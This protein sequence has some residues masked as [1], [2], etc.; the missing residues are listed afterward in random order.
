MSESA[1]ETGAPVA[2]I[3]PGYYD[4]AWND[5][6]L[7]SYTESSAQHASNKLNKRVGY[8]AGQPPPPSA[9][10]PGNGMPPPPSDAQARP[11]SAKPLV[12]VNLPPPPSM[13]APPPPTCTPSIG[14]PPNSSGDAAENSR[15]G[16]QEIGTQ[17]CD[18]ASQFCGD[19][20]VDIIK[21]LKLLEKSLA[22]GSLNPRMETILLEFCSALTNGELNEAERKLTTLGADYAGECAQWIIGLRHILTSKQKLAPAQEEVKPAGT[23]PFFMPVPP[24]PNQ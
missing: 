6:P 23:M 12:D 22:S 10:L 17:L 3:A 24:T 8:P 19:K 21:R 2:P 7:F 5:P 18:Q 14:P 9:T 16:R 4:R 15:L 20:A 13:G 1:K 11:A